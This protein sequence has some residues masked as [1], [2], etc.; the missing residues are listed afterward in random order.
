MGVCC[1]VSLCLLD[2]FEQSTLASARKLVSMAIEDVEF[3][4]WEGNLR[5]IYIYIYLEA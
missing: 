4:A 1:G 3:V 2:L 5:Y